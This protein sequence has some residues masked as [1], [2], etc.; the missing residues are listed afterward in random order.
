MRDPLAAAHLAEFAFVAML[1]DGCHL[2]AC[3]YPPRRGVPTETEYA[4]STRPQHPEATS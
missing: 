2:P 4:G 1:L 3:A